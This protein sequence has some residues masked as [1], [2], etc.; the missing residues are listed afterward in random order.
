MVVDHAWRGSRRRAG[1]VGVVTIV[2]ER[3]RLEAAASAARWAEA[4]PLPLDGVPFGVKDV[5]ATAGVRTALGSERWADWV[6]EHDATLVARLLG[7]GAVLVAKLATPELAFGDAGRA[8]ARPPWSLDHWSAGS[9]RARRGLASRSVPLALGTDTGGSIRS[10]LLLRC[11]RPEAHPRTGT[12]RR[13]RDRLLEIDHTGPMAWLIDDEALALAVLG[14]V[15]ERSGPTATANDRFPR[16]WSRRSPTP[17]RCQPPLRRSTRSKLWAAWRRR[18]RSR[19]GARRIRGLGHHRGRVR[20]GECPLARQPGRVLGGRSCRLL[21]GSMLPARRLPPGQACAHR[22]EEPHRCAVRRRGRA[23]YAGHTDRGAVVVPP[24]DDLWSDGAGCGWSGWRG[25]ILFNLLGLP[26]VAVAE[27]NRRWTTVGGT[28]RR[29]AF[30]GPRCVG[31]RRLPGGH[32][33]HRKTPP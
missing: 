2:A 33:H 6:R 24:V 8:T 23:A 11:R 13:C 17:R 16:R 15:P 14:G 4:R 18:S 27:A 1:A 31:R 12:H 3:A 7:A 22:T 26:A 21:A 20:Q 29:T 30:R 32:D 10:V 9:C 28:D 19:S 5:I 25:L